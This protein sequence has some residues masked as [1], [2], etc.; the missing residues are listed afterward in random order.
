MRSPKA[1]AA[2]AA[3][4]ARQ[5]SKPPTRAEKPTSSSCRRS[6]ANRARSA[7]ATRSIFFNFRPDRARQMTLA[8]TQP[9]F[10]E[11]PVIA[12]DDLFFA[13]MTRYEEDMT[14]PVLFGPRPQSDTFGEI[15]AAAGLRATAPRRDRKVRARH[16]LLQ[17][18]PRDG[19]RRRGPHPHPIGPQRRHLRP[20]PGNARRRDHRRRPA[21]T[22]ATGSTI[23]S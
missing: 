8:F 3:P 23:L 5:R 13:T 14:N 4:T 11:F 6:S 15:V 2:H 17:R 10:H 18:R 9:D 21:R 16:L 1:R 12:Y 20:R 19:F 7:T 22:C